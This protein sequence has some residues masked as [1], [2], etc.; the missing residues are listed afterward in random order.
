MQGWQLILVGCFAGDE[1]P[2]VD[3]KQ[4]RRQV[5]ADTRWLFLLACLI[6]HGQTS[7]G[8]GTDGLLVWRMLAWR[9]G[10][11]LPS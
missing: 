4:V 6:R 11:R 1:A 5:E 3:L 7:H 9:W 8:T 2:D 10:I